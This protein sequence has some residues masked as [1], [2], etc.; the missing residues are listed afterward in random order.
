MQDILKQ[1]EAQLALQFPDILENLNPPAAPAQIDAFEAATQQKLPDDMR[2]LYLWHDGCTSPEVNL[3]L[4]ADLKR[5]LLIGHCRWCGLNEMLAQWQTQPEYYQG[6]DYFF[7]EEESTTCWQAAVV[8]PWITPPDT[9]LP[10]GR[11]WWDLWAYVDLL[12]GNK[13]YVGQI[14]WRWTQGSEEYVAVSL[15]DYF[16]KLA[17]ALESRSL[18]YDDKYHYWINQAEGKEFK[19]MT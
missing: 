1:L 7:T 19:L 5:Y 14:V 17:E 13:G 10:I 2:A 15:A 8:R 12:P 9:W 16:S 11:R 3:A 18:T 4:D 6:E